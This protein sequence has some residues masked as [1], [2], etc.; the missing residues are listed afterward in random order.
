MSSTIA[1]FTALSGLHASSRQLDVIGDNIANVNTNGFKA[2]RV[3][4]ADSVNIAVR[5]AAPPTSRAPSTTEV[6]P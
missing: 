5:G 1:M 3:V 2:S 6:A 4:F